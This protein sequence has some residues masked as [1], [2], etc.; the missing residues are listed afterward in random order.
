VTLE[1]L[2]QTYGYAALFVGTVLEGETVLVLA[3]FAAHRGYLSLPW[4]MV[5]AFAGS[6][7]GDQLWFF[8]GRLRGRSFLDKRPHW[9]VRA[10]RVQAI[11]DRYGHL[12][13]LAM[14]FFY[15]L[16][17]V[18]PFAIG[19][20]GYSPLRYALWNVL[21]AGLW[22][23]V[24]GGAGFL[25]GRAMEVLLEDV[26]RYE[27]WLLLLLAAGGGILWVWH[28]LRRNGHAASLG[29]SKAGER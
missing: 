24:L 12:V 9:Q 15:G 1:S 11:L 20:S 29:D 17:T 5:T 7:A 28:V 19:A 10:R 6:L 14:R 8:V 16:R 21:G 26:E 27:G 23:F 18:T 13:I 22:A 4:V 25:F 2:I 3:G